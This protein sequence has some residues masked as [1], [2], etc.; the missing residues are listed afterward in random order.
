MRDRVVFD[1]TPAYTKGLWL[2]DAS[3]CDELP[4]F[5]RTCL[6]EIQKV[7]EICYTFH[8]RLTMRPSITVNLALSYLVQWILRTIKMMSF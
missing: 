1:H 2:D 6:N 8:L 5:F 3:L 4:P 7:Q